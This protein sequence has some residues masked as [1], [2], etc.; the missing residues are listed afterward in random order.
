M[1]ISFAVLADYCNCAEG[2]KLNIMGIFHRIAAPDFPA[3]HAQA[4]VISSC[5]ISE[6]D[7]GKT[8]DYRIEIVDA[9]GKS[10]LTIKDKFTIPAQ[11]PGTRFNLNTGIKGL[12]IPKPGAYS[13]RVIIGETDSYDIDFAVDRLKTK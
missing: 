3:T 1:K 13:C 6:F 7:K 12:P 8:F 5:I 4:H 10:T 2:G 11:F 9:D